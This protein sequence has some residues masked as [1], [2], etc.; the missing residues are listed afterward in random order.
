VHAAIRLRRADEQI[1]GWWH[2]H[3]AAL[4]PCRNCPPGRRAV[5][6]ANR[7]FF[8]SMDVAFH[9][10]AFQGAH[11]IALLL[12]F[13]DDPAPGFDLFGWRRGWVCARDYYTTEVRS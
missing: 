5:C 2:S 7:S 10:T 8:S 4:W 6:A 3:P 9:R 12:S 11:N 13:L 1:V